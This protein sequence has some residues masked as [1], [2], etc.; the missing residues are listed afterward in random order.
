VSVLAAGRIDVGEA[1]IETL[2]TVTDPNAMRTSSVPGL[3]ERALNV[4]PGLARHSCENTDG[5]SFSQEFR[6]TETAHLLEHVTIELMA[7]A[8][9]PRT[10]RGRTTWDFV[11]DGQG[12]FHVSIEY[13]DDIVALGAS[14]NRSASSTG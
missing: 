11:R 5:L 12:V 10:L 6:D 4:L 14:K 13:D 7:L 3:P 1:C 8:G 9:S 2:V